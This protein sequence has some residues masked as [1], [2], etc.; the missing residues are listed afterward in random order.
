VH[1]GGSTIVVMFR[2]VPMTS[3]GSLTNG[4]FQVV[5]VIKG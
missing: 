2:V 5:K 4:G 3:M 1:V